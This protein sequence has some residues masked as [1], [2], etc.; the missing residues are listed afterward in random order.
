MTSTSLNVVPVR[1]PTEIELLVEAAWDDWAES[2]L[3]QLADEEPHDLPNHDD[4]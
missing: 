1:E 3:R 4:R 2:V